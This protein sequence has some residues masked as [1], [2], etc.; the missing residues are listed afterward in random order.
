VAARTGGHLAL[1][2]GFGIGHFLIRLFIW[3]AI[4]RLILA[5]WHIRVAGPIIV[6][7]VIAGLIGLSVYRHY[8]GPLFRGRRG[9]SLTGYGGGS[10]PRDW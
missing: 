9:G 2:G 1:G 4:W 6:I 3:H 5:V 8:R 10:S 7:A